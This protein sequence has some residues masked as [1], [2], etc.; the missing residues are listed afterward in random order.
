MFLHETGVVIAE[1]LFTDVTGLMSLLLED[2]LTGLNNRLATEQWLQSAIVN[3]SHKPMD[4][5]NLDLD[6][7]RA[8]NNCLGHA[9]GDRVILDTAAVLRSLVSGEHWLARS[10]PD[11][12]LI[13]LESEAAAQSAVSAPDITALAIGLC[14]QLQQAL[15]QNLPLHSNATSRFT[16]SCGIA[17]RDHHQTDARALLL[18]ASGALSQAKQQGPGGLCLFS[19]ELEEGFQQRLRLEQG[20]DQALRNNGL[21]LHYQPKVDRQG[22]WIGAEALVRWPLPDGGMISPDVFIPLAEQTGQIHELGLWV[23]EEACSQLAQWCRQG[24]NPPP[25]AINLSS[26]QLEQRIQDQQS[27][28]CTVQHLCTAHGIRCDQ[29]SFELTETAL[30]RDWQQALDQLNPLADAGIMLA[31]DDFGTGYSSL[32]LLQTLPVSMIK[33]DRSFVQSL[34][35][36]DSDRHL[37]AGS[38]EIAHQ[39]GLTTL[40][41]GVETQAQWQC[42]QELGC[43]SYQGY[44]F[45]RPLPATEFA[46]QLQRQADSTSIA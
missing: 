18:Q 17:V 6:N 13:V 41:E 3:R 22:R 29:L 10:G 19:R 43:D 23:L 11:E 9:H 27:L 39:L 34:P 5:I 26:V 25:L 15:L 37:V 42:L 44:L 33:I 12:F 45:S 20:L 30:L 35:D 4:V 28:L 24:L 1:G 38:L 32:K 36:N 21:A 14:R 16:A 8:A 2:A 40:A 46:R 31:I 7:F